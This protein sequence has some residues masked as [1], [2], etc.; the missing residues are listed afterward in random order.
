[1]AQLNTRVKDESKEKAEPILLAA[2]YTFSSY[3]SAL[4]DYIADTGSLPFQIRYKPAAVNPQEVFSEALQKFKTVWGRLKHFTQSVQPG[5]SLPDNAVAMAMKDIEEA[6]SF[7][8]NHEDLIL[9]APGQRTA[10]P[11]GG[12]NHFPV[13]LDGINRLSEVLRLAIGNLTSLAVLTREHLQITRD[14]IEKAAGYINE[15]QK[16]GGGAVSDHTLN[17]MIIRDSSEAIACAKEALALD[18]KGEGIPL[19]TFTMWFE[20]FRKHLESVRAMQLR[21]GASDSTAALTDLCEKLTALDVYLE[22]DEALR[23]GKISGYIPNDE[24]IVL[25]GELLETFRSRAGDQLELI[26]GDSESIR[27]SDS[28]GSAD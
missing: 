9:S 8:R 11:A 13:S 28:L 21:V 26:A 20:R 24:L 15:L 22:R 6:Y 16:I 10:S 3:F 7:Y 25:A 14:F 5:Q 4:T 17:Q 18:D 2:G 1:M 27:N 23:H 19:Y 12:Y